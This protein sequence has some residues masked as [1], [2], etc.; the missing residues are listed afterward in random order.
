MIQK[1]VRYFDNVF[2]KPIEVL[3]VETEA[4]LYISLRRCKHYSP[5]GSSSTQQRSEVGF[6]SKQNGPIKINKEFDQNFQPFSIK[7]EDS[8]GIGLYPK[9]I[10]GFDDEDDLIDRSTDDRK[11]LKIIALFII[12]ILLV[13]MTSQAL[14]L[15]F[16][17]LSLGAIG[18]SILIPVYLILLCPRSDY[19]LTKE[20]I[21]IFKKPF[22]LSLL[23]EKSHSHIM[24]NT[25]ENRPEITNEYF[26]YLKKYRLGKT[27][28]QILPL[29]NLKLC[30]VMRGGR[31]KYGLVVRSG[32]NKTTPSMKC[33][34]QPSRLNTACLILDERNRIFANGLASSDEEKSLTSQN[35]D[36]TMIF[37]STS[38]K[39]DCLKYIISKIKARSNYLCK[40]EV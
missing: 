29:K 5:R 4:Q 24:P 34:S 13:V 19:L 36:E 23:T 20:S 11:L 25:I 2:G 38:P 32:Y 33:N 1:N 7:S 8:L 15:V 16:D 31:I 6:S 35:F 27:E 10:F 22:N 30:E 12:A 26:V 9:R 40:L 39:L 14:L 37:D 28:K 17:N 18:T 21:L 3:V